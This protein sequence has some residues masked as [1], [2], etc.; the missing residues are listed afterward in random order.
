MKRRSLVIRRVGLGSLARWGFVAG[1]LAACLPALAC[2]WLLFTVTAG[3]RTLI[4]GWRDFGFEIL[5][6]RLSLNL[7][8]LLNLQQVYDALTNI[9]SLGVF[10]ILLV[11]FGAALLL[12]GFAALVAAALGG[13]YNATGRVRIEADEVQAN[14]R[15]N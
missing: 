12:G 1:A 3:L 4:A 8:D 6:Q 2:S 5:G 13:L 10:G 7:V 11:A 15:E 9:S 14:A